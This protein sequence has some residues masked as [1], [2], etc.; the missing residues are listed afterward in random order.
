[1]LLMACPDEMYV[2]Y[3]KNLFAAHKNGF[4]PC[5]YLDILE[6]CFINECT[7]LQ[8]LSSAFLGKLEED[9]C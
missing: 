8:E 9:Y 1:M 2:H 3:M 5:F 7:F 4:Q 6:C